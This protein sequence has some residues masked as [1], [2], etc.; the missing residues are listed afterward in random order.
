MKRAIESLLLM[1][2]PSPSLSG[3]YCQASTFCCQQEIHGLIDSLP[4]DQSLLCTNHSMF[5]SAHLLVPFHSVPPPYQRRRCSRRPIIFTMWLVNCHL[6]LRT[7]LHSSNEY[8]YIY[9]NVFTLFEV[10]LLFVKF[11]SATKVLWYTGKISG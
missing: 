1:L 6:Y 4:I 3:A 10:T 2:L 9:V 5:Q 7:V 11:L 8:Y